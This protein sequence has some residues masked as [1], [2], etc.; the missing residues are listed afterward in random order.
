MALHE[1]QLET[2]PG[3][4]RTCGWRAPRDRRPFLYPK[5]S[6]IFDDIWHTLGLRG[7]ASNE[8]T[9]D[10]LFVPHERAIYR[11]DP[12][13][14]RTDSP[15]YRFSSNQLYSDRVRRRRAWYRSGHDGRVLGTAA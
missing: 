13:D 2:L 6:A 4:V 15:L 3:L 11:D 14:R 5:S 9:V 10:N 8:Y 12:R 1:R 7:T